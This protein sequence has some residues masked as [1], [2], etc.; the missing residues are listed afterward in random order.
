MGQPTYSAIGSPNDVKHINEAQTNSALDMLSSGIGR[1]GQGLDQYQGQAAQS[2][3]RIGDLSANYSNLVKMLMGNGG[4][5]QGLYGKIGQI[6][7]GYDPE[8]GFRLFLSQQPALQGVAENMARTS[9]SE[10]GQN[11]Q[12]LARETSR[13]SL[14]DTASQLASAGLLGAGAGTAAMTRSALEPQLQ[15]AT[16]LAGLR[17]QFLQN[18][19]GQ[20]TSQGLAQS[21]GAY[22]ASRESLMRGVLGQMQGIGQAGSLIGQ[23]AQGYGQMASGYSQ[24]GSQMASLLGNAQSSYAGLSAPEYWQ[25][26]YVKDRDWLDYAQLAVPLVAGLLG[27]P[28][29]AAIGGA[30]GGG[31]SNLFN[32][33]GGSSSF[34]SPSMSVSYNSNELADLLDHNNSLNRA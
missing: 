34:S 2:L 8:A 21:Q 3:A 31:L 19:G 15:A 5:E 6:A 10:T 18:V 29:G 25:P 9:L 24:L 12:E 17:S 23:E 4:G 1:Y 30:L 26:Q 16:Q 22:D 11:A 28:G 27:G 20:L 7:E 13:A 14:S 32:G 33:G